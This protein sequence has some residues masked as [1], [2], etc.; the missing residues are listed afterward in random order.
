M[1]QPAPRTRASDGPGSDLDCPG[2]RLR[3]KAAALT[4]GLPDVCDA[5]PHP[6]SPV[7]IRA[8][9]KT[10]RGTRGADSSP[11]AGEFRGRAGS[12]PVTAHASPEGAAMAVG[13]DFARLTD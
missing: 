13:D 3:R 9:R 8:A 6:R 4:C 1:K 10:E 5:R 7:P 11:P 2:R 12:V